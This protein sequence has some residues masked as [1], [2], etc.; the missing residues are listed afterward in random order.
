MYEKEDSEDED[1]DMLLVLPTPQHI[2]IM[3]Y[4]CLHLADP[5]VD[6]NL[7]HCH[8]RQTNREIKVQQVGWRY[9]D[10]QVSGPVL[11]PLQKIIYVCITEITSEEHLE[12]ISNSATKTS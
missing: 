6:C 7:L 10:I 1:Q 8:K 2:N 5:A 12:F 3:L 9:C 11:S 4:S